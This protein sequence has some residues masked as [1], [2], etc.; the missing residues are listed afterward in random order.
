L[1]IN[2]FKRN[3]IVL[4]DNVA[5]IKIGIPRSM[6]YYFYK[7]LWKNFFENLDV[8]LI[9][10]PKTN[11]NIMNNGIKYSTDEMCLSLKNYIG[12]VHYLI[13]KCDYILIPRIDNYGVNNQTCTNFLA[14]YDI[15][16]NL[17]DINILDY[18]IDLLNNE[19]EEKGLINIGKKLG[20]SKEYLKKKYIKTNKKID[21]S[22]TKKIKENIKNLESKKTKIL[23]L[24]HPYNLYDE[25]IGKEVTKYLEKNNIEIIY[26]D[27]FHNEITNKL[28]NKL[29]C[30]L[31]WK[32]SKE[33][34]GCIPLVEKDIQGIIF[35]S[36]FPCGPDSIVNELVF[37]KIKTPYLN[38]I[39]DDIDSNT[40]IETRLESFIDIIERKSYDKS[41]FSNNG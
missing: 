30:E 23:L 6:F 28:S 22:K 37:K 41:I 9:I 32:F 12:H 10:S 2:I 40:G 7:D 34:I 16:N 35:I 14:V 29:A 5:K 3:K 8:E 18:N 17:F 24:G 13:D 38:L 1:F 36:S 4:G 27:L 19:T 11:K 20:Y 31:Y 21:I 33:N 25:L 26:S 15:I 39:F